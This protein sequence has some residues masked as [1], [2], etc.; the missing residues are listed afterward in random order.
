GFYVGDGVVLG[1]RR[2]S[3]IDVAGGDQPID[4]E[5]G[6]IAIVFNGEIYNHAALRNRLQAKGHVLSSRS[7]TEVL[8]HLYEEYGVS[9]VQLLQGMFGF[10]LWDGTARRLLIARD[11]LGIKPLYYAT[12]PDGLVFSS[13]AKALFDPPAIKPKINLDALGQYL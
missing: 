12:T 11:R 4:N 5:D 9:C 2:L 7:D 10:P 6:S 13:E 8:V 1:A 3:I